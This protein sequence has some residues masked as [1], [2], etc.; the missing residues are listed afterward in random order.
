MKEEAATR[1]ERLGDGTDRDSLRPG[2]GK[3]AG[4]V[5][6]GK[7][8]LDGN[9]SHSS[10]A[11][12]DK[13]AACQCARGVR[14]A[15][16]VREVAG[17]HRAGGQRAECGEL[18][19]AHANRSGERVPAG[20]LEREHRLGPLAARRVEARRAGTR[21]ERRRDHGPHR[22]RQAAA[23]PLGDPAGKRELVRPKER[24]WMDECV[25]RPELAP[26]GRAVQ[27]DDDAGNGALSQTDANEVPGKEVEPIGDEVTKG[28]CGSAEAREY[29][30]LRGLRGHSS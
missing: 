17:G 30:D 6:V 26:R 23:V 27:R 11:R 8:E 22:I 24:Q 1:A 10:P 12:D 25:D 21:R 5:L 15:P 9:A 20:G 4:A 14:R 19:C 2:R 16:R 13:A 29:G 7:S 28:A 3:I 18:A